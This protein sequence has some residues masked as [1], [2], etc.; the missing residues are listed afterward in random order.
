MRPI[1]ADGVAWSVCQSVF[2]SVS[3]MSSA[4]TAEPIAMPF[5]MWTGGCAQGT[6]KWGAHWR[7]LANTTEPIVC[8]GDA[9]LGQITLTTL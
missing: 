4:K 9:A 6:M 2:L 5:G 8:V 7:Y 3:N 1:V